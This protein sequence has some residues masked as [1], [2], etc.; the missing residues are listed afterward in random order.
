MRNK[1]VKCLV[2]ILSL[3]MAV[4]PMAACGDNGGGNGDTDALYVVVREAGYGKWLDGIVDSYQKETGKKVEVVYDA[5]IDSQMQYLFYANNPQYDLYFCNNAVYLYKWQKDGYLYPITG[6]ED[7]LSDY[8]KDYGIIDGSRYVIDP[9]TPAFGF[10]Y[11]RMMLQQ[12]ESNGEYQ[13]GVFPTTWQGL[14]DMCESIRTNGVGGDKTIKPFVYGGATEDLDMIFKALWAQG[15]GGADFRNYLD[16]NDTVEN[17]ASDSK[18]DVFIND[19][20]KN[21]LTAICNLLDSDGTRPQNTPDC[22]SLTNI[23][24]EQQFI[25]GKC[26][27]VATGAWFPMEMSGSLKGSSLDYAFANV[28]A[29][30]SAAEKTS[31]VNIPSEGFFIPASMEG[32][33]EAVAFLQYMFRE[34][35]CR[36]LHVTLNTP[37]SAKYTLTESEYAELSEWGKEL[38]K[39]ADE[40]K[41]IIKGSSNRLFLVGGLGMFKDKSGTNPI[42]IF[43]YTHMYDTFKATFLEKVDSYLQDSYAGYKAK[44]KEIR[45]AAGYED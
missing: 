5:K 38:Y 13:K 11:N 21:A 26:V 23:E 44:W 43:G 33:D 18:K 20:V 22:I 27:F 41:T 6:I 19:S 40:C 45:N 31:L 35:N 25:N 10:A 12:I 2:A 24:A 30:D 9:M 3:F 36:K 37:V 14:L 32:K 34:D 4:L 8:I 17:F 16:C 29:L 1:L 28:P 39:T 15:N 42:N 7:R